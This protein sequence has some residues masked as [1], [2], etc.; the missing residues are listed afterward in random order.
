MADNIVTDRE[1]Q[2]VKTGFSFSKTGLLH[3]GKKVCSWVRVKT[4]KIRHGKLIIMG[5]HHFDNIGDFEC[6]FVDNKKQIHELSTTEQYTVTYSQHNDLIVAE[7]GFEAEI[8]LDDIEHLSFEVKKKSAIAENVP[9]SFRPSCRFSRNAK[10]LRKY[11]SSYYAREGFIISEEGAHIKIERGNFFSTLKR[12]FRFASEIVRTEKKYTA[13][14]IRLIALIKRAVKRRPLWIVTDREDAAGDNGEALFK[15]LLKHEKKAKVVFAI[16][17]SCPDYQRVRKLG[18]VLKIGSL[19]YK[20]NFLA[21]DMLISSQTGDWVTNAFDEES[22][23]YKSMFDFDVVFLQH[24]VIMT[25]LAGWFKGYHKDLSLFITSAKGEYESIIQYGFNCDER[26]V[27]LTGLP[28]F[29]YLENKAEKKIVFLPTW[30]RAIAGDA[31]PGTSHREYSDTFKESDYYSFYNGLINNNELL[32]CMREAGYTGELYI[33]PAFSVQAKDFA[34]N[35]TIKVVN[36]AADY[37]RLFRENALL[38][39]D[40]SSVVADFAYMKKPVIY[41]QFD[42][43]EFFAGHHCRSGYFDYEKDGFGPVVYDQE[44]AVKA[45]IDCIKSGCIMQSKYADRVDDFFAYIDKNNCRRVHEAIN[46]I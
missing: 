17:G 42:Y 28:R 4:M 9:K 35:E 26:V 46:N 21:A 15:Y 19:R 32:R 37:N 3:D 11:K 40:Y 31:I 22:D 24:G 10:I 43:E 2:Q 18:K 25:D 12:E 41:T 36:E 30:R 38:I 13:A 34:G 39:T 1:K 5:V 8:P 29:D 7:R 45:I 33:H 20:L 6:A 16:D 14:I 44:A 27:K 23:Y